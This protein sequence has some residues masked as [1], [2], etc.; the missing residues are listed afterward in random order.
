MK[1]NELINEHF[2][3]SIGKVNLS[4]ETEVC[5]QPSHHLEHVQMYLKCE[6]ISIT[7]AVSVFAL[8][9]STISFYF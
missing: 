1:K 6:F 8:L 9:L 4:L 7:A 5:Q 2:K 3:L